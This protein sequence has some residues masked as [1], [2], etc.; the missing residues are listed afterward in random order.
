MVLAMLPANTIK[1]ESKSFKDIDNDEFGKESVDWVVAEG[2]MEGF[3]DNTFRS[4][5]QVTEN[6]F[7]TMLYMYLGL[8]EV[9][10]VEDKKDKERSK[11]E[12][13][14]DNTGF[15]IVESDEVYTKLRT[16]GIVSYGTNY[17]EMRSR[18]LTVENAITLLVSMYEGDK[19]ITNTDKVNNFYE[20][21]YEGGGTGYIKSSLT[22][23]S[24]AMLLEELDNLGV[25][26]NTEV[27]LDPEL[28]DH[29]L[30]YFGDWN[31][32]LFQYYPESGLIISL[33]KVEESIE[34]EIDFYKGVRGK[35]VNIDNNKDNYIV[36]VSSVG[37][38]AIDFYGYAVIMEDID[39]PKTLEERKSFVGLRGDSKMI[40][41]VS[42]DKIDN[43]KLVLGKNVVPL[44][45][46][47]LDKFPGERFL[48]DRGYGLEWN[49]FFEG[50]ETFESFDQVERRLYLQSR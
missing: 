35:E 18:V 14:S 46:D 3:D 22:R 10:V 11:I 17:K 38:K 36:T 24:S 5:Q 8:D 31:K 50:E 42:G 47:N 41:L 15:K 19:F 33:T 34:K 29:E 9:E 12:I 13:K 32:R 27:V 49:M 1:G 21:V 16:V 30:H 48:S 4:D 43:I 2:I 44:S 28:G 6:Q 37:G 7:M 25:E 26:I 20:K 39:G 45:L 40:T 23:I